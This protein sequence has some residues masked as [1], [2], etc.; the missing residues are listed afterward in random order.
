MC[1]HKNRKN[2]CT[3]L[4]LFLAPSEGSWPLG[5][6]Q[7]VAW[8]GLAIFGNSCNCLE[9]SKC[10]P[11]SHLKTVL[12]LSGPV[13]CCHVW[14]CPVR[15]SRFMSGPVGSFRSSWTLC[16]PDSQPAVGASLGTHAQTENAQVMNIDASLCENIHIF[17]DVSHM[18]TCTM[19]K[20][21][22]SPVLCL[23]L[24]LCYLFM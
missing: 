20:E 24:C 10:T 6:L 8:N 17:T 11:K 18:Q 19:K 13:M 12:F 16:G 9:M 2:R 23:Y 1:C 14:S 5:L 3:L 7:F 21:N 15:Y 4:I 22:I